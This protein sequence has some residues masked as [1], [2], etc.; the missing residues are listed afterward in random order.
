MLWG[1]WIAETRNSIPGSTAYTVHRWHWIRGTFSDRPHMLR[2]GRTSTGWVF[3]LVWC[4]VRSR[5][6]RLAAAIGQYGQYGQYGLYGLYGLY[7]QC[8]SLGMGGKTILCW[9]GW[10]RRCLYDPVFSAAAR[11]ARSARSA[12]L[13]PVPVQLLPTRNIHQ[14]KSS[15]R[16]WC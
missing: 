14:L 9:E 11:S 4:T 16:S 7:G 1:K 12:Y 3:A 10:K 13:L 2:I 8:C 5:Q 6:D 15:P